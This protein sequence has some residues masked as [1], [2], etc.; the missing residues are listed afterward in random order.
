MGSGSV[1]ISV[2]GASLAGCSGASGERWG[3][4]RRHL[5]Y[6]GIVRDA[7]GVCSNSR[8]RDSCNLALYDCKLY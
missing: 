8:Q 6:L 1:M 5:E 4:R 2:V 7:M 3:G